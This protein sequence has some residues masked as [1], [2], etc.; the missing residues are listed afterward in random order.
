[1]APAAPPVTLPEGVDLTPA[2]RDPAQ[3]D[4]GLRAIM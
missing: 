2:P 4:T 1:M 3:T